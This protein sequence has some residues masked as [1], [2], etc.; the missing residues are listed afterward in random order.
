MNKKKEKMK[1]RRKIKRNKQDTH[2]NKNSTLDH[3]LCKNK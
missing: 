3:L 1:R 2:R